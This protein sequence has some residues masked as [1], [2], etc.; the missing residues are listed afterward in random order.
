MKKNLMLIAALSLGLATGLSSCSDDKNG[1]IEFEQAAILDC[2]ASNQMKWGAYMQAVANRLNN[3]AQTLYN[4]WTVSFNSGESYASVFKNHRSGGFL[5]ALNCVEQIIDGCVT[6]ANEVGSAKI[7]DPYK[8]Y[9]QGSITEALYAVESWYSWHSIEDYS[10]NILSVRNAY[11]GSL[12][13]TVHPSSL[14]AFVAARNAALDNRVKAAIDKAYTAIFNDMEAPFRNNIAHENV[15]KAMT[16]CAD[17]EDV[18]NQQLKPYFQNNSAQFTD[19]LLDPVVAQ[20]VDGV[21]VPTYSDLREKVGQLRTAVNTFAR[22]PSNTAF[23]SCAQA[24]FAARTPWECSEGFL[25]GPVA[26]K[27]LDPN[28]D[29]WPLDPVGIANILN[30]GDFSALDWSGEFEE[31]DEDAPEGS[32][33]HADAIA[34]AQSLRGFH[35]LEY[36]IFKDGRAR[37][38]Q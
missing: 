15:P 18:L 5:S 16:A 27:G 20:Y 2:T 10:N 24:W 21:V 38:I 26:D 8:L 34:A 22:N 11:F 37:T 4:D 7:G 3:D 35:T 17:L 30:S 33:P 1:E 23:E 31:V 28:M 12:D 6:I 9:R 36:L 29:S 32:N 14:S 25:F 13:G 19:E